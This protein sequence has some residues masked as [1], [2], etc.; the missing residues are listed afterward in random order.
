MWYRNMKIIKIIICI[1]NFILYK[2]FSKSKF[3][4]NKIVYIED[5]IE[6]ETLFKNKL[7]CLKEFKFAAIKNKSYTIFSCVKNGI[8]Y[9]CY[10][11]YIPEYRVLTKKEVEKLL[12]VTKNNVSEDIK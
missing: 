9:I 3:N 5:I 12:S 6:M 2:L 10:I 4:F 8:K 7:G 1:Y 11:S